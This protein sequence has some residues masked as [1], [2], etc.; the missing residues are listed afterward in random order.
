MLSFPPSFTQS[1]P[2]TPP[3]TLSPPFSS[4]SLHLCLYLLFPSIL[5]L[6]ISRLLMISLSSLYHPSLF[7]HHLFIV[8]HHLF[9]ISS[10]FSY[11]HSIFIISSSSLHHPSIT[12]PSSLHH[13]STSP[14]PHQPSPAQHRPEPTSNTK[15][16]SD[17]LLT[18]ISD[19]SILSILSIPLQPT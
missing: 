5:R 11:H 15:R 2:K 6:I 17:H 18:I 7:L 14:S 3:S 4:L 9:I 19:A 16:R 8:S 12:P 10:L 1:E 13:P